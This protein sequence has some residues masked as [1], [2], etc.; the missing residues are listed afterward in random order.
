MSCVTYEL[1]DIATDFLEDISVG[2]INGTVKN[3]VWC[4]TKFSC[5]VW[6]GNYQN[7]GN[8]NKKVQSLLE[9]KQCMND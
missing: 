8:E 5:F 9:P 3:T 7:Y 4:L 1:V 6:I 2:S